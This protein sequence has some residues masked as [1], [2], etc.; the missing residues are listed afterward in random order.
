MSRGQYH[1]YVAKA[2]DAYPLAE[3]IHLYDIS[4]AKA[5]DVPQNICTK[6]L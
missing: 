2:I 4:Q 5:K 6:A 1:K 3:K